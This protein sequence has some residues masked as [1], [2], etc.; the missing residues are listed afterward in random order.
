M[1]SHYDLEEQEQ[2]AQLKAFWAKYGN[3]ITWL[4]AGL[5][6][7]YA[8]Y[9]GWQYWEQRQAVQ[10]AALYDELDQ[11]A[12]AADI[13]RVRRIWSDLQ[14]QAG[15]TAQAQQG[16]LLAARALVEAEQLAD[17]RAALQFAID[18]GRDE[19]LSAVARVRM[20][21]LELD[22]GNLDAALRL[23]DAEVPEA[24]R[25]WRADRRGDVLHRQGEDEAARA[26]YLD[27]WKGL[28]PAVGYRAIVEAKLNALG[29]DPTARPE[30]K[31]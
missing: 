23:L 19:A 27:A 20:A 1:A 8:A 10:A 12:R 11:A 9:N 15:R 22:A 7:V 17:A 25:P 2:I 3:L 13:E 6:G 26:A 4:V 30:A 31:P 18:R 21:G 24:L 29:V 16:A 14:A 5:L 28:E